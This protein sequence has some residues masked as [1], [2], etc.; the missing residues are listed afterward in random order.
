M[1]CRARLEGNSMAVSSAALAARKAKAMPQR[2]IQIDPIDD[3][4]FDRFW[5]ANDAILDI[6][7]PAEQQSEKEKSVDPA[8]VISEIAANQTASE[9]T[10]REAIWY[11]MSKREIRFTEDYLL[12]LVPQSWSG[13]VE[14]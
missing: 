11:L 4:Q 7:T 10:I 5:A 3:R 1:V 9:D 6:L 13:M 2:N 14:R 8:V 12:Q